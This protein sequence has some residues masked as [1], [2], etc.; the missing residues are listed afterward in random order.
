MYKMQEMSIVESTSSVFLFMEPDS[1]PHID[2]WL[3]S[4]VDEMVAQEPFAFMG[5][6]SVSLSLPLP[7]YVRC[8][9]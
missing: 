6:E 3:V 9:V 2:N 7:G 5:S 1:I 8:N 4:L